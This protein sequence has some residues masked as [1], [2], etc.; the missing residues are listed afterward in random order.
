MKKFFALAFTA[1]V[2]VS[3]NK[4]GYTIN[5][6]VKGFEDGT[7]VYINK[8]DENGFTKIDSTVVKGGLFEFKNS[9]APEVDLY[10]IELDTTK[11]FMY[12]MVLEK[13]EIK[14]TFDKEKPQEAKV[15]GTKNNDLM[16]SYNE[17]A[18]KIQ[19]EIMDFQQQNQMKFMEAQQKG[20]QAAMQSISDEMMSLQNKYVDQNK[21]FISTNKDSYISLLLLT[22]LAMSD[23]LTTEEI[24]NYYNA[25]DASVKDTKKGKEFSDNLKKI[26]ENEKEHAAKQEKVAIG[27]KAPDFTAN[28]PEGKAESLHKNLGKVTLVDFWASWCGPC[29]KENPNVVALYNKYKA[30][31]FKV[32]G[33]SLDK[34]KENWVKAIADDKLDWLQI[35]NLKYWDDEIAK[36]Y[37]IDAIPAT[38]LLD[39]NGT[40][41]AKNLRGAE[42]EAKVAELLK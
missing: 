10:F 36:E 21:N 17:E 35:S 42:L 34:E 3:C 29:R 32:I 8:Q 6:E 38:I 37:A 27:K 12:P 40:I 16:T 5:G 1:A 22:Q 7:K 31:G 2:L 30:Q 4:D 25:F 41:V 11:M 15:I 26:E 14:F 20:D 28:T 39:A 13:G 18:S 19:K 33:V 9:K 24:K 23:A